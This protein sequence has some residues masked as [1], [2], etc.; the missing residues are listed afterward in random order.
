MFEVRA[1][2][3]SRDTCVATFDSEP[4]ANDY[5][6]MRN[7]DDPLNDYRVCPARE[8]CSLDMTTGRRKFSIEHIYMLDAEHY[9]ASEWCSVAEESDPGR[10]EALKG[11]DSY[12]SYLKR[13]IGY[14]PS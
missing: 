14:V 9:Y 1:V 10:L 12:I 11:L 5:A 3:L 7:A 2:S 8:D 4:H 13:S 6:C